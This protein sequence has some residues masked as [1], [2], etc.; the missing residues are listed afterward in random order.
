MPGF[1]FC[2]GCILVY[3]DMASTIQSELKRETARSF[4]RGVVKLVIL[5]CI[6]LELWHAW[7]KPLPD[8]I[9]Y[10]GQVR[11]ASDVRFLSDVTFTDATGARHV[12]QQIFDEVM[13]MIA[14]AEKLVLVDMFLFNDFQGPKPEL[15]RPLSSELTEALIKRKKEVPSLQIVFITDPINI[16]YGGMESSHLE[17]LK[18]AGARVVISRLDQLH[19]SNPAYSG[20][21]RLAIRHF[22]NT[23]HG[24][25]L[26]NPFGDGRVSLMS[27]LNMLNFKANHR[28]VILAD[29]REGW[30]ALVTSANP[31]DAS[32][33][34]GNAAVRFSGRAVD[35]LYQSELAVIRYSAPEVIASLPQSLKIQDAPAG[36]GISVITESAILHALNDTIRQAG[37]GD[38]LDMA[39]FY[40]S[41]RSVI[42][43][44]I[45]A[46]KRGASVRVMLDPN[47]DAF[48]HEKNGIPNRP[49]A[50]ELT[51]SG[52]D[53]RWC[54]THGEQCHA[55]ILLADYA[56]G[57]S[58]LIAGSANFTR[59][60]L[61]DLNLETDVLA[62]GASTSTSFADA[63]AYFNLIWHNREA[64]SYSL[65]YD[66]YSEDSRLKRA[67]YRAQEAT[68]LC[69]F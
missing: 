2:A 3:Y 5:I 57:S 38:S 68:G 10:S 69:T 65:P 36:V 58:R 67:I 18:A 31:H 22:G 1:L 8:G 30:S 53:V 44:L 48:G 40:L 29:S 42:E 61:A 50:K 39:V 17:A 59:R 33:A 45:A 47:F 23:T 13:Q 46:R 24:D 63:R 32:S 27:W 60:N 20:I 11:E 51:D 41:E 55:K 66:R 49:V 62:E 37:E 25:M 4:I 52:I 21:W 9:P 16:V 28:K 7:L 54:D 35:D 19:D 14:G 26:P 12:R 56:S 34:H 64:E 6:V 43:D 15:T